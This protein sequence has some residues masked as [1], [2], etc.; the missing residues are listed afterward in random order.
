MV[1]TEEAV[2]TIEIR[3]FLHL[4]SLFKE[5]G[6]ISPLTLS[7]DGDVSGKQLLDM[8]EISENQVEAVFINGKAYPLASARI[9]SGD[10]VALVPPGTPGPYRVFL[11]FVEI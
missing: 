11:G 7:I 8:L 6:W 3:G 2:K 4:A 10:R 1:S 9:K 5:R